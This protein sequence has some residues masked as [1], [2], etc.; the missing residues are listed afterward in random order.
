MLGVKK[1]RPKYFSK[2]HTFEKTNRESLI[3]LLG[4]SITEYYV[5]W[6]TTINEWN[7]DGPII[8]NINGIQYEF[9]AYELSQYSLT[10]DKI[11]IAEK[12]NWYGAGDEIRLIW[13]RNAFKN[14]NLIINKTIKNIFLVEYNFSAANSNLENNKEELVKSS[15]FDLIGI[16]F[17]FDEIKDCLNLSNGLDCN[18]MKLHQTIVNKE[19]R[20]IKIKK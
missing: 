13:R 16:E 4:N 20:R 5:Q 17:E 2:A 10:I 19:Y 12:L 6:D 11:N 15:D 9:T 1:Y 14:L 18:V 3:N 7:E 8:L